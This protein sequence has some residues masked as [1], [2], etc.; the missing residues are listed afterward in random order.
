MVSNKTTNILR[1]IARIYGGIVILIPLIALA[2][3][4]MGGRNFVTDWQNYLLYISLIV[5]L[6]IAYKWELVGGIL[7]TVGIIVSGF[8]HPV[9]LGPGILYIIIGVLEL[10]R[11]TE[12][13]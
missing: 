8:I 2:Q 13:N 9:V 10:K 1:W 7:T 5:G 12:N 3:V 4:A 11:P 6:L